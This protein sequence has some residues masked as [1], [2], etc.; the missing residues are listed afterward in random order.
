M[1]RGAL[2][3]GLALVLPAA[4]L[5]RTWRA[6]H[7]A[8]TPAEAT[9]VKLTYRPIGMWAAKRALLGRRLDPDDPA[10]GR[11]TR[12]QVRRILT[13]AW[14]RYDELVPGAHVERNMTHGSCQNELLAVL[15]L[16]IYRTLLADGVQAKYA[17]ELV[18]DLVWK[19]YEKWVV[20]PRLVARWA[21]D[22]PQEQMNLM[23]R[24]FL[25]YP[26]SRPGYDWKAWTEDS[27]AYAIDFYRCPMR[28][29]MRS[30]GEEEFML[31]SICTLDFALAQVMTGGGRYQRPHTLSAGDRVCDMKWF[32]T[33]PRA[34]GVKPAAPSR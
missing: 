12:E 17:T 4:W 14:R 31:N 3:A 8:N 34:A 10:Q 11:F 21:K 29:Y 25:R 16:A 20:L 18:T 1:K 22:D 23:L 7:G 24:M 27:G 26:F 19:I 32:A 9:L 15:A 5:I 30:Q 28:D 2:T 13:Q 6:G 33:T